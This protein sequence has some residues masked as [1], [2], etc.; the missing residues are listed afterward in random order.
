MQVVQQSVVQT[1]LKQSFALLHLNSGTAERH[2]GCS[3]SLHC[4]DCRQQPATYRHAR[5]SDCI[6]QPARGTSGS[7]RNRIAAAAALP[8][9][10]NVP[11]PGSHSTS[12][13]W[14]HLVIST[15]QEHDQ[16]VKVVLRS[17]IS[18]KGYDA[19]THVS[20]NTSGSSATPY[21]PTRAVAHGQMP[22]KQLTLRPVMLK[23][24][25]QLQLSLLDA[26]QVR[27]SHPA[28]FVMQQVQSC[29]CPATA[30]APH[31]SSNRPA[32]LET[33]SRKQSPFCYV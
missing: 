15:C 27:Y 26:R 20:D 10:A 30:T 16:L 25:L 17:K 12:R 18:T 32:S 2:A 7:H 9:E 14:H 23:G 19:P 33:V 21:F 4:T 6:L 31:A 11:E 5:R 3:R 1:S 13:D 28:V 8:V 29:S 24:K 22:Y